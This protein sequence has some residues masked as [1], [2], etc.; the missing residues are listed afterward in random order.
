MK[1]RM[2]LILLRALTLLAS[3]LVA[4]STLVFA[5]TAAYSVAMYQ[6]GGS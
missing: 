6:Y 3:L 4:S 1:K 2:P 5:G